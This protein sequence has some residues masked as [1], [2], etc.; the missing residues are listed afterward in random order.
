MKK[1]IRIALALVLALSLAIPAA[2]AEQVVSDTFTLTDEVTIK[3]E[4]PAEEPP[5]EEEPVEEEPVEEPAQEQPTAEPLPT[6][7]PLPTQEPLPT[8]PPIPTVE[9]L[10]TDEA[11]STEQ[12]T[13]EPPTATPTPTQEAPAPQRSVS[14]SIDKPLDAIYIGDEVTFTATL[15]G[16]EGAQV[17]IFWECMTNGEWQPTGDTGATLTIVIDESNAQSSWRCGVTVLA[18]PELEQPVAE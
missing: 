14:I 8:E 10:P 16:Y 6:E 12:P 9:P 15:H 2:L 7:P 5:V 11:L 17:E 18:E 13:G 3:V 1:M 4:A